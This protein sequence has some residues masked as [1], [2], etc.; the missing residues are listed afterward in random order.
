MWNPNAFLG[1]ISSGP[2]PNKSLVALS[3]GVP[4]KWAKAQEPFAAMPCIGMERS[5]LYPQRGVKEA[6]PVWSFGCCLANMAR[7][8][9]WSYP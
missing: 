5:M 2:E 3:L 7:P 1:C 6:L 8:T 9:L 4:G